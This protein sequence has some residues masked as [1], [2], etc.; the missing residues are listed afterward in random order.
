M[1]LD[2]GSWAQYSFHGVVCVCVHG[3]RLPVLRGQLRAVLY[4]RARARGAREGPN[5]I[6]SGTASSFPASESCGALQFNFKAFLRDWQP[7]TPRG[8]WPRYWAP[9]AV[10]CA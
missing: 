3:G 10:V 2:A 4:T 8:D 7:V 6:L 5:K 1:D 9:D